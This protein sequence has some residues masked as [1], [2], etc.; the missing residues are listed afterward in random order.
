M[1]TISYFLKRYRED[2]LREAWLE[3]QAAHRAHPADA[4]A[5]VETDTPAR[6]AEAA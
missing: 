4:P 1:E 5:P 2:K 3:E 6:W